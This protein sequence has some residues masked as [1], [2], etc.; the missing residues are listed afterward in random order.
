MLARGSIEGSHHY[1]L[2]LPRG[3]YIPSTFP[4]E[5]FIFFLYHLNLLGILESSGE[6]ARFSDRW[7]DGGEAISRV[8]FEDD[9]FRAGMHGMKV[10][11]GRGKGAR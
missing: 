4:D 11:W 6:C 9:I 8:G 2:P 3:N 7:N 10:K 5:G 1:I